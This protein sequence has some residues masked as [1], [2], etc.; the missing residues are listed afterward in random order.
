[1]NHLQ[2]LIVVTALTFAVDSL[3]LS[4]R[5]DKCLQIAEPVC[6]QGQEKDGLLCYPI[7]KDGFKGVGPVCWSKKGMLGYGR[8]AGNSDFRCPEG[9][10]YMQVGPEIPKISGWGCAKKIC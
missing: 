8:S 6:K 7:C 1:M 3:S 4:P 5:A 10:T 2:F 9:F